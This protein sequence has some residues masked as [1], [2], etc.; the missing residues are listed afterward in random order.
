MSEQ[1]ID[2]ATGWVADHLRE[3]V[4]SDGATGHLWR[5]APTL[6]LTTRGR[7]SGSLRRTPLIYGATDG[8][9]VVVASKGGTP[10]H[11]AW[12]LNLSAEP[13]VTIQLCADVMAARART[14]EGNERAALWA[15]MTGI[16]PAYDTYQSKT[17]RTIPVVALEPIPT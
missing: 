6:L 11:P 13:E 7:R 2:P 10:K 12:Y 8:T 17:E 9:Y 3:Y 16:W 5:G 4:A 1:P 14:A 15:L